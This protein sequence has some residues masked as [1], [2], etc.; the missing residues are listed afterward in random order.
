MLISYKHHFFSNEINKMTGLFWYI[1]GERE[2][3][4]KWMRVWGARIL[5][6]VHLVSINT[7]D[8]CEIETKI[9]FTIDCRSSSIPTVNWLTSK[10]SPSVN[11]VMMMIVIIDIFLFL[12]CLAFSNMHG[13]LSS[14]DAIQQFS[15][16]HSMKMCE[17]LI[18]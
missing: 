4:I 9:G 12:V 17:I 2:R 16:P 10:T 13:F 7:D 18:F 5:L 14:F 6:H 8:V 3:E 1:W 11:H 15:A